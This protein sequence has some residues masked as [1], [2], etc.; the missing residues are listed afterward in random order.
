MQDFNYI[1][2]PQFINNFL[3]I[4]DFGVKK[5]FAVGYLM[6]HQF[7]PIIVFEDYEVENALREYFSNNNMVEYSEKDAEFTIYDK[8]EMQKEVENFLNKLC[9]VMTDYKEK[10][11]KISFKIKTIFSDEEIDYNRKRF[12]VFVS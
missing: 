5:M 1:I 2:S 6:R 8:E 10:D 4:R 7:C 3:G 12:S 9:L 11:N